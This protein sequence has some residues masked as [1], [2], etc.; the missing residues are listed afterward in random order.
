MAGS[1]TSPIQ[2]FSI[3]KPVKIRNKTILDAAAKVGIYSDPEILTAITA[4]DPLDPLRDPIRLAKVK[5]GVSAPI[6]SVGQCHSRLLQ[7]F[8]LDSVSILNR[9]KC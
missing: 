5:L 7:A 4:D 6:R 1:T 2:A 8:T 3:S 9:L